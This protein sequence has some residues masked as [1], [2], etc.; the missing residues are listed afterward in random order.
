MELR[1]VKFKSISFRIRIFMKLIILIIITWI[2]A[3]KASAQWRVLTSKTLRNLDGV[4]FPSKDTGYV[5]GWGSIYST[6]NGGLDWVV[7]YDPTYIQPLRSVFF[8]SNTAGWCSGG[9]HGNCLIL[10]TIDGGKNWNVKNRDINAVSSTFF[11]S[12]DT[13][14]A[15][16]DGGEHV[17]ARIYI[18]TDGGN[19]WNMQQSLDNYVKSVFFTSSSVGWAAGYNGSIYTT[20]NGGKNWVKQK[21]N[22]VLHFFSIFAVSAKIAWAVGSH[23]YGGCYKTE[24]GGETWK[25]QEVPSLAH[26]KSV[27][28]ST[29]DTGWIVGDRGVILKTTDGGKNWIQQIS[30]TKEDLTSVYF[31]NNKIGYIV[32]KNGVILKYEE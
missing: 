30:N 5:I 21:T 12:K 4:F 32:G 6:T 8:T 18:T 14:W 9:V 1:K 20:T 28:F 24:D 7:Q 13:G 3:N 29:L 19:T 26:L 27:Y 2:S 23:S 31:P 22:T 17:G 10:Q 11:I 25:E 16:G 15:V